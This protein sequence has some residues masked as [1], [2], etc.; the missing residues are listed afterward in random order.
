G[1]RVYHARLIVESGDY[2]SALIVL[3]T[4]ATPSVVASSDYHAL[5]ASVLQQ[6]SRFA[7]A[8]SCRQLNPQLKQFAVQQLSRLGKG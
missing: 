4:G 2:D 1:L 7:E 5:L 8:I 3:Q 6:L